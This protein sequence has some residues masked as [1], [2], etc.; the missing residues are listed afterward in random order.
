MNTWQFL[1]VNGPHGRVYWKNSAFTSNWIT[2]KNMNNGQ[3]LLEC[4]WVP[5]SGWLSTTGG[6]QG[7]CGLVGI[8]AIT[9]A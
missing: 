3:F 7:V 5:S 8:E 6:D 4:T 1:R 2:I 9:S